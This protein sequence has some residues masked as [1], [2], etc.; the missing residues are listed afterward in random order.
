MV[1]RLGG[2]SRAALAAGARR[3]LASRR[4]GIAPAAALIMM[5]ILML[6]FGAAE[7]QRYTAL[8]GDVQDALDAAALA[9][10]RSSSSDAAELQQTGEAVLRAQVPFSEDLRLTSF[11]VSRGADGLIVAD[12]RVSITPIVASL[13]MSGD[14]GITGHSEVARDGTRMEIALVLDN[15]G[16]M[17]TNNRIGIARTAAT[18]F[19]TVLEN[20][21]GNQANQTSVRIGVVP[22]AAT[23]NV[24][25]TYQG[26]AWL[27]PQAQSPVHS[28]LFSTAQGLATSA[29]RW[30]LLRDM[31]IPWGGCVESRPMP[32]D[33]QD[34]APDP[35]H[36]AT[37]FVPY[38]YPDEADHIPSAMALPTHLRFWGWD[39][40]T[41]AG[42]QPYA[43]SNQWVQDLIPA[44]QGYIPHP[45]I[46][47]LGGL[48]SGFQVPL[49]PVFWTHAQDRDNVYAEFGAHV[50]G[51]FLTPQKVVGKYTKA[52][53][54]T[55]VAFGRFN[56]ASRSQGPNKSCDLPPLTRL[57]TDT[58]AVKASIAAM[59][60]QARN[61]N[62]PMGLVWG[63]HLLSPKGPFTDG[64][65]Y[66]GNVKKIIV[67]MTDGENSISTATTLNGAEY[68]GIGY[69]WQNRI[70]VTDPGQLMGGLNNRLSPLCTNIKNAGITL[71]TIRVE[72]S[73][74]NTLLQACATDAR[75]AFDVKQASELDSAF[76]AIATSVQQLRIAS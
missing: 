18:N 33:I 20:A 38:F 52:A 47:T 13:F 12:A 43:P 70:G 2:A 76:R 22:F 35:A 7:F 46:R 9:V 67:L 29:N 58:T 69:P 10:A 74:A 25:P 63:W 26:Q 50:N 41:P 71:Y 16:S 8:R 60:A 57:T 34:T 48:W 44:F 15:T 11:T 73:G 59:T 14:I 24:G 72:V 64:A 51:D 32:F 31:Q 1:T 53:V 19:V 36:P 61:T 27:D 68:S 42:I 28:Q 55:E 65:A 56:R 75:K 5:P 21:T 23:V 17:A 62:V 30:T 49:K 39:T 3:F 4:G 54:D 40:L 45:V 6:S 37:L 66:G